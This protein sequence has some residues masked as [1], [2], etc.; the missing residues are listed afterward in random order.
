MRLTAQVAR[1][2]RTTFLTLTA[3]VA[4][5]AL[6]L[7]LLVFRLTPQVER[8]TDGARSVRLSYLS[9]I[10]QETGLRAYL[11]TG[12]RTVLDPYDR[13]RAAYPA[14]R[15]TVAAAFDGSRGFAPL[16]AAESRAQ[17]AWEEQWVARALTAGEAVDAGAGPVADRAFVT[18][19]RSLFDA[20]RSAE[21]AL[22]R[23]ADAQVQRDRRDQRALL[24][25]SLA[26]ELLVLLLAGL[27][28]RRESRL[29]GRLVVTPVQALVDHIRRMP[30]DRVGPAP[31]DGPDEL[32]EVARGLD[33]MTRDLA[34]ERSLVRQREADL[35]AAR[36]EAETATAAKSAFLATMSHEIRTPM[37]AVIG[38]TS[39]LLDTPLNDEQRDYA[40]T[41]RNSGDALLVIINDVLDFSKIE[42]GSLELEHQ[43]FVLRDCVETAL[44]LVAAQASDKGLELIYQIEPLVPAVVEGDVTRLRQVL[45]NLLS[46]AVKFTDRGEVV[47]TVSSGDPAGELFPLRFAVRDT[48][49]GIPEDRRHRL[50]Q[51]FSQVDASTTRTHG[52][53]GLGLAISARLAQ[54]MDG[55]L[56]VES[57]PGVGSTFVLEAT[58]PRGSGALDLLKVTPAELPGKAALIVDDNPTNRRILRSQLEAWGM[59][60]EEEEDPQQSI[61]SAALRTRP[62]DVVLLDMHMPN[63]DGVGVATVLRRLEGWSDVPLILLTS[64]GQRPA[65]TDALRL[66]HLTKPVKALTLRTTLAH[67][68]GASVAAPA[69]GR[70]PH[71]VPRLRV[72]VA[73]DNVVNQK[74]A[75]LLLNR[76]GQQA[77][78]VSNGAEALAAVTAERFDLVLMD[79]LMPVM[80]GLTATR[81]IRAEVPPDN[82]PRIVA[83]TATVLLED[84][85]AC[86]AAGMDDYLPKPVRLEDL[87]T[88][89][90]RIAGDHASALEEMPPVAQAPEPTADIDPSVL[91]AMTERLG[92]RAASFRAG[93]VS[94][95]CAE[96]A[97]Q[98]AAL[99]ASAA[100]GDTEGAGRVAHTLKSSSAALGAT[101]LAAFCAEL[102]QDLR[103]GEP[104][105]LSAAAR[106]VT[107]MLERAT[108]ELR[109]LWPPD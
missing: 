11:L 51:S 10:D 1:L 47:V 70:T 103:D 104:R 35:V 54:A 43:P 39:L 67:A 65:E 19:G 73:E 79:V 16:L 23:A 96:S 36:R 34:V 89:V 66:V 33:D 52:G 29:L 105:D 31:T 9:M 84:R 64:L 53:T 45:V 2:T 26:V 97:D 72:L 63:L 80:D 86:F 99:V 59:T 83:M 109:R 15:R 57:T 98:A 94:T 24:T 108:R 81:R 75:T 13:G 18:L 30:D 20:Y 88:A 74:V 71:D 21:Q 42:S 60:V 8:H 107:A 78:I 106:Q 87:A 7:A 85:E 28:V 101:L 55:S 100:A 62:F 22:E 92:E 46:N 93:L 6:V 49:I 12:D 91:L 3:V 68:L 4:L 82:Q 61:Q 38:M 5:N 56:T 44:D 37:N 50:F 32:Q 17:A 95:Y 102:E 27:Y 77:R 90:R 69:E 25:G 14:R 76:L 48:G 41:V 40:E 58:L